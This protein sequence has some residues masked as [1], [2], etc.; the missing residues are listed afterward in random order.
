MY[1]KE[2]GYEDVDRIHPV[3]DRVRWC[4]SVKMLNGPSGSLKGCRFLD[5]LSVCQLLK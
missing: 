2:I 3:Q 4:D 1:L 5:K